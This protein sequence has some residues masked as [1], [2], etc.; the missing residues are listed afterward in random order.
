MK[1][2]NVDGQSARRRPEMSSRRFCGA[3][4]LVAQAFNPGCT[5][6]AREERRVSPCQA[7]WQ[8]K[9]LRSVHTRAKADCATYPARIGRATLAH[10]LIGGEWVPASGDGPTRFAIPRG[11]RSASASSRTRPSGRRARSVGR[12]RGRAAGRPCPRPQR[13]AMLFRFAAAPRGLEERARRASSRSSRARRSPRP[14]GEVGR[15]AAEARF[16]AGEA[17]RADRPDVSE[18][19][20]RDRPAT[21]SPSRSAVI[22]AICPWNFPVVTPVRKIAPALAWGNTVVFKPSSLTPWSAVYLT[23]LLGTARASRRV[24]VNLVTGPGLDRRRQR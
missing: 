11:R 6:I 12:G 3:R 17:S 19:A 18:R 23:Q 21:P 5:G 7:A 15:A 9:G 20:R 8:P 13:G 4:L 14:L 22:A 2:G 1:S 16:M 24:S 10:R